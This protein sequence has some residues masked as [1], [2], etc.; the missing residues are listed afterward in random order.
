MAASGQYRTCPD[1]RITG[2]GDAVQIDTGK[3]VAVNRHLSDPMPG[4][5]QRVIFDLRTVEGHGDVIAG[6][7]VPTLAGIV[8]G[9]HRRGFIAISTMRPTGTG[10][11]KLIDTRSGGAVI[12]GCGCAYHRGQGWRY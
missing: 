5:S 11:I 4:A 12:N 6:G 2:P 3:H 1:Q 10:I 7:V 8:K 9:H